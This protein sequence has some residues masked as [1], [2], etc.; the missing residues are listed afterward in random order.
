MENV[1][2]LLDFLLPDCP[3]LQLETL[4]VEANQIL[5][6]LITTT[7]SAVCP[8]CQQ[9]SSKAHSRYTRTL[10]DLPWAN[11]KVAILLKVRRF[12][13][14]NPL[15]PK[16]TFA[17]RLGSQI[18]EY[19]RRTSRALEQLRKLAFAIGAA[20]GARLAK[21]FE[22]KASPSTLLR[23]IRKTP[24]LAYP[25]PRI[26]GVDDFAFRRGHNYGTI[27][28]DL[29]DNRHRPIELLADRETQTL[30]AWLKAH[31]AVQIISRDRA[32]AYA[33]AARLGAPTA[34]QVADR[35]HI[36]SNLSEC[37]KDVVSHHANLIRAISQ[38]DKVAH[39]ERLALQK[40]PEIRLGNSKSQRGEG[41]TKVVDEPGVVVNINRPTRTRRSKRVVSER[42]R[43]QRLE[44][45]G[46]VKALQAQGLSNSQIS[47]QL[48]LHIRTV[49]KYVRAEQFPERQQQPNRGSGLDYYQPY[50]IKRW[51]EGCYNGKQLW[52]EVVAQ[53]YKGTMSNIY[54]YLHTRSDLFALPQSNIESPKTTKP[55]SSSI[56][57]RQVSW[58]LMSEPEQL[59]EK[60]QANLSWLLEQS[61]QL[62]KVYELVQRFTQLVRKKQSA[63]LE[64]WLTQAEASGHAELSGFAS[65]I[66]RDRAAVEAALQYEWSNGPV[67]GQINR[68][69]LLKRSMY[70][71]AKFDL[72]RAR[73]LYAA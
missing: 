27:L 13:C 58:W 3:G 55:R 10:A 2:R 67:E 46:Q 73:V 23:L 24:V 25:T 28:C 61:L 57:A 14:L 22:L 50:L 5:L 4:K 36:L 9:L 21:A 69:K 51:E 49:R 42:Q 39:T 11:F 1:N 33:E 54:V 52:Q 35:W 66:R 43:Q 34:I 59:S 45:Y 60:Q 6:R 26:L 41:T 37:V 48:D 47:R 29:E 64:E 44:W 18:K 19:A 17:Q 16:R 68:L 65:G 15:C 12:L 56:S 70:G 53:G 7:L 32:G 40:P 31:P 62:V 71:R 38:R 63:G 20:A 72:L 30:A 8:E